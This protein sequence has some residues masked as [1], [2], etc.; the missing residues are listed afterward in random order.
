MQTPNSQFGADVEYKSLDVGTPAWAVK[1][2]PGA[3]AP[4][5][6]AVFASENFEG[7]L[8]TQI[9]FSGGDWITTTAQAHQGTKSFTNKD[10]G[11][12]ETSSFFIV[13]DVSATELRFWLMTDTEANFDFFKL[14]VDFVEVYR[15][16]GSTGWQLIHIPLAAAGEFI[17]FQYSKDSSGSTPADAC[18]VDELVLGTPDIPGSP[19]HPLV[20]APMQLTTD[21]TR[22]KVDAVFPVAQHVIIDTIPEVEIK[23]DSG[24]PVPVSGTV[25]IGTMPEVEIKNDSGSPVP[26]SGTV[27]A[28]QGTSPWVVGTHAVT[29]G[30]T[31]WVG[32]LDATTLAALESITVQNPGGASAVNI[33]DGGNSITV[34]GTVSAAQSGAWT[35][36]VNNFPAVQPVN[37]NGGSLTVDGSVTTTESWATG[38]LANGVQTTVS[39]VAV[40]ILAAN[41]S[42]KKLIIQ[43][44]GIMPMRVGVSGVTATTGMRLSSDGSV[45]FEMPHCPTQAIFAIRDGAVDT[46]ALAQEVT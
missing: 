23:N 8:W 12:S 26:V 30:T 14:F 31:P 36:G 43:N 46:T 28:T 6:G 27:S 1:P 9:T 40:Q 5:P 18:F 10:I 7:T 32:S 38:T 34:D 22:L 15:Q 4:V 35:V 17:E 13:N 25:N 33:Q 41:A 37:D 44:V 45:L 16:S 29:Q 2:G 20:Y 3:I 21:G 24:S 11:S 42:R 39:S 19:A